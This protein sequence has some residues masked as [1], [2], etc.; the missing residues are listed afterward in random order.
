MANTRKP[1]P[2]GDVAAVCGKDAQGVYILRRRS[3]DGPVEAGVVRP[4]VEGKAIAGEVISLRPRADLPF[5]FDVKTE[6]AAPEP[7]A[8]GPAQVAT[9][10]YRRGWDAIW[11][12]RARASRPN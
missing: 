10:S 7:A 5:L 4:L 12:R 1:K 8:H 2:L 11:G 6:L 3:E 9:D